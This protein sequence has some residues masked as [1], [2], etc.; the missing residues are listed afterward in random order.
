MFIEATVA[1]DLACDCDHEAFRLF[2]RLEYGF[3]SA[4]L[5]LA[6]PASSYRILIQKGACA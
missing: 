2:G 5:E 4:R 1:G 3:R 6:R